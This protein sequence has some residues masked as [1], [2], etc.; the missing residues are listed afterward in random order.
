MC[1]FSGIANMIKWMQEVETIA[2]RFMVNREG[3][4]RALDTQ[5]AKGILEEVEQLRIDVAQE[6]VVERSINVEAQHK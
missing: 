1:L 2:L 3:C 4:G 6:S 5:R